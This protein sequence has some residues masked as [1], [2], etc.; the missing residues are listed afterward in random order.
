MNSSDIFVFLIASLDHAAY[1]DF[2]K[3]RKLIF[4]KYNIPHMFMFDGEKPHWFEA[5]EH[6]VFFPPV[7]GPYPAPVLYNHM[8]PHMVMKF[9]KAL[10]MIDINKYKYILRINLSTYINFPLLLKELDNLPKN[11]LAAGRVASIN[12]SNTITGRD[13][14]VNLLSGIAH[15]YSPDVA[16][17]LRDLDNQTPELY[18]HMDD[19]V[20]SIILDKL[21]IPLTKLPHYYPTPHIEHT[22]EIEP[23]E[24]LKSNSIIRVKHIDRRHDLPKWRYL[25]KLNDDIDL[26]HHNG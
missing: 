8:N 5:D 3:M 26:V 19:V 2:I 7:P 10:A 18:I 6:D 11:N 15:I 21:H 14:Q 16:I 22:G 1:Y 20:L 9:K 12:Y 23:D 13:A 24:I 4:K 25:L 17:K